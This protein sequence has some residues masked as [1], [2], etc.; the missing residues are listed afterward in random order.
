MG[1]FTSIKNRGCPREMGWLKLDFDIKSRYIFDTQYVIKRLF[2][3]RR[4]HLVS[5]S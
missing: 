2:F 1:I 5:R 4:H 3:S